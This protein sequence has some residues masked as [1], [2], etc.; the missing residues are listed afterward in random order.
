MMMHLVIQPEIRNYFPNLVV[1]FLSGTIRNGENNESLWELINSRCSEISTKMD[2][3]SIRQVAGIKAGK[4]AYRE[5]GKDPNRYRLSAEALMRRIVKG[6][7]LYRINTA[8]DVL[9]LVSLRSGITIGGFD[10]DLVKGSIGLGIGNPGEEFEAIGRG[11]LNV[12]SLPVYRDSVGVIGNP[13][14]DCTRTRIRV[15]TSR[16][17]MLITGFYGPEPVVPVLEQLKELLT[18][19]CFLGRAETGLIE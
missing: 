13:T 8:V 17:L 16:V 19:Y 14:S 6:Q 4:Q 2:A 12:E 10:Y 5:L 3:E 18:E 1:G 11:D 7:Q 15:D 9:N